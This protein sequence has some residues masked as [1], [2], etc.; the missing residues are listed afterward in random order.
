MREGNG[1]FTSY[2]WTPIIKY[3]I[4]KDKLRECCSKNGFGTKTYK[5][6]CKYEG[7]LKNGK[8][9]GL[10]VLTDEDGSILYGDFEDGKL[11]SS[12]LLN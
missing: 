7:Y 4:M 9:H 2:F 11:I 10:G 5:C 12:K 1:F 3:K 8:P 6:G